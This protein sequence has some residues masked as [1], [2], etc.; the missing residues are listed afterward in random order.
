MRISDWS[1]DVCS[2]DLLLP[3]RRH[4]LH[5]AHCAGA[6]ADRTTIENGEAAALGSYY[7]L[8]PARRDAEPGRCFLD[9]RPPAV[10]VVGPRRRGHQQ[11]GS[12]NQPGQRAHS[13]RALPITCEPPVTRQRSEEHTSE[14][15]S[16][17]RTSYAV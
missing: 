16:L 5:E 1:S 15:Q 17:M 2:S 6:T 4:E 13:N 9:Q 7:T 12:G 10:D 14:L 8:D 11:E 3:G